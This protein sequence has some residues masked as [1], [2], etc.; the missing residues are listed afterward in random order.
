MEWF[1]ILMV[2]VVPKLPASVFLRAEEVL[3]IPQSEAN[4]GSLPGLVSV[5]YHSFFYF[6]WWS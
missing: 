6:P 4:A 3:R 1:L 5:K 2:V